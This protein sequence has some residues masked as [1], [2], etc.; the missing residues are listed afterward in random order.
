MSVSG[1]TTAPR[2]SHEGVVT[3]ARLRVAVFIFILAIAATVL[4]A[5]TMLVPVRAQL[6]PAGQRFRYADVAIAGAVLVAVI[7]AMWVVLGWRRW[8]AD[9]DTGAA[10]EADAVD[11][12]HGA[13]RAGNTGSTSRF[14]PLAVL[15]PEV[16]P[17]RL[18]AITGLVA[19]AMVAA[20]T[21][22]GYPAWAIVSAAL[23]PWA[24]LFFV[25]AIRKYR[26][27][28]L[29]VVFGAIT[30]LQVGHL[31]EHMVQVAQVFVFN[32][33][34][35]RAHGVF[36]QLD[37]ETVHFTWDSMVWLGLGLLLLRFGS[38]RWLWI[39]FAAATLHEVEHVYL[40][41]IYKTDPAFYAGGGFTGIMG[42]SGVVGSP[43]ARP[44]LHFAYNVCAVVPLLFA[45][46]DQ[47]VRVYRRGL[48]GAASRGAL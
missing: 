13:L 47:T 24:P 41:T 17:D 43:L 2:A 7:D 20:A 22:L 10:S 30:F 16:V 36:G 25:E 28:G 19:L 26:H 6:L 27:Y 29:Y 31:G 9:D 1:V 48:G 34:L 12:A 44:Y 23:I 18:I 46:W 35:S 40:F 11:A 4:A 32:G 42:Q 14:E 3:R 21:V 33:D 15:R 45:F 5:G 37:F 38:N 39:A 8:R